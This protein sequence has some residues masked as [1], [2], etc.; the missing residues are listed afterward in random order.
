[1]DA[2]SNDVRPGSARSKQ[3]STYENDIDRLFSEIHEAETQIINDITRIQEAFTLENVAGNLVSAVRE[4]LFRRIET[5]NT[6]NISKVSGK[7]ITDAIQA[8]KS[9]PG[10]TALIS[11]GISG[12][13]VG[14]VLMQKANDGK[15][16]APPQEAVPA[17]QLKPEVRTEEPSGDEVTLK[18]RSVTGGI[19]SWVDENPLIFGFMGLSAGLVIG[20]LTHGA[21]EG[22][23]L[24]DETRRTVK[25][26]TIQILH[27]TKEKAG[28]IFGAAL[29][30]AGEETERQDSMVH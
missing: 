30:A 26:K 29:R 21:L 6:R 19:S 27:D 15:T 18:P 11:L 24:L 14:N 2:G 7:V 5:M 4:E 1:M 10:S 3:I 17:E 8:V 12:L 20:I 22:N 13:I 28:H 9:H 23:Q 16:V 25:K